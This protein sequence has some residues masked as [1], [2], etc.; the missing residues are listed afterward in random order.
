MSF[1][2]VTLSD[3]TILKFYNNLLHCEKHPAVIHADGTLE[4]WHKGRR[5]NPSNYSFITSNIAIKI[6]NGKVSCKYNNPQEVIDKKGKYYIPFL[7]KTFVLLQKTSLDILGFSHEN[8]IMTIQNETRTEHYWR[9]ILH[10]EHDPAV[11]TNDGTQI[12]YKYG[13]KHRENG[14]AII[15]RKPYFVNRENLY[16]YQ[17]GMLHR[18]DGPA[19]VRNSKTLPNRVV[20]ASYQYGLLHREDGPAYFEFNK[21]IS[22]VVHECWMRQGKLHR[23]GNFNKTIGPAMIIK[24]TDYFDKKIEDDLLECWFENGKI[25]RLDGPAQKTKYKQIYMLSDMFVEEIRYQK[26]QRYIK[27]F[28]NK[29]KRPLREDLVNNLLQATNKIKNLEQSLSKDI[30]KKIAT[31]AY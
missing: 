28:L 24:V 12:Y 5:H 23:D 3:G 31:F 29:L 20:V 7:L 2:C 14:P 25:H 13:V 27:Y 19:L 8:E 18:D 21:V 15:D 17:Y 26:I 1:R 11:T 10:Q 30:C 22:D 4:W 9:G 16:W 6:V